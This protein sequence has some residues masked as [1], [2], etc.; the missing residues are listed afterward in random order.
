MPHDI[1]SCLH[2]FSELEQPP[3]GQPGRYFEIIRAVQPV[4]LAARMAFAF[5]SIAVMQVA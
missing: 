2:T 1:L 4:L 5:R 3:I